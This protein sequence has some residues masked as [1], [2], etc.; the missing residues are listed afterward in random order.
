MARVSSKDE[1]DRGA[2]ARYRTDPAGYAREVL[3]VHWWAKQQ[4]IAELLLTPPYRVLVKAS[5]NIGKT[6]LA[7]G[8]VNWWYDVHDPGLTL[9]TAPTDTQVRDLLWKEVRSQRAG[10]PGFRGPQMPRLESSEAHWAHGF[11]A[12]DSDSFQGRH[13]RHMLIVFD[14]AVGVAP[15]F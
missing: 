14:E 8:L 10:R 2:Y 15:Q 12:K 11:T 4:Q 3:G 13:A 9:T 1:V 7:G 6:H 5:H